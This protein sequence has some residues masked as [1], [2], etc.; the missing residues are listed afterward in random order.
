MNWRRFHQ[1]HGLVRLSDP[2]T[3]WEDGNKKA[4]ELLGMPFAP[5][6]AASDARS[7]PKLTDY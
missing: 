5:A 7:M 1:P 4:R 2:T 6:V 3:T